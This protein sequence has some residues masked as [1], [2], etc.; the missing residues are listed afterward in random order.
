MKKILVLVTG[1]RPRGNTRQLADAFAQGAREAGHEVKVLYLQNRDIRGCLGC[2]ACRYGKPCVQKD[3]FAALVPDILWCD[4]LV[5]ASPLYFWT[6]CARMKAIIERFYS[7]ARPDA[8]PPRGRY[9][10]YPEKDCVLLMT[11]A[12][13]LFW[14]FEQAVSYYRFA[15][16]NYI[17][18]ADRGVLLAGGCGETNG[19]PRIGETGHLARAHE[20]GRT[21]YA[22]A[23]APFLCRKARPL[24]PYAAFSSLHTASP[25]SSRMQRARA[26]SPGGQCASYK[27]RHA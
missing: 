27:L 13:D 22:C 17:G 5:F 4:A 16:V 14:T 21:L 18:F 11:A 20:F 24:C 26:P 3:D 7:L 1:G 8:A 19:P 12:D 15:L 25:A 9:E 10:A 2:N 6:I 23:A